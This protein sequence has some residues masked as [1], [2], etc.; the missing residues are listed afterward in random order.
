MQASI[1]SS[2]KIDFNLWTNYFFIAFAFSI[3][4]SKALIS[5]FSALIIISWFLEKGY[6]QKL[7]YIKQDS[8]SVSFLFLIV[9]S[10]FSLLWSPD[11]LYAIKFISVKYW[12][13]LIIPIMLTS[14]Q[15]KYIKYVF[16]AFLLSMLISEI[17]SYGIFFELWHYNNVSPTD[18]SPFMNHTDYSTFLSFALIIILSKLLTVKELLWKFLYSLY[19]ITGLA[20]LF[21]NGGR[22]GQVTFIITLSLITILYFKLSLKKIIG[23]F[24]A[25][26]LFLSLAYTISPNFHERANQ[27]KTDITSMYENNDYTGSLSTRI[28]LWIVGIETFMDHPIIGTGIGGET[29]EIESYGSKHGFSHLGTFTDYHN[30]FIQYGVQLGII[31]FLIPI[32]IFYKLFTLE[33]QTRQYKLLSTAFTTIYLLHAMGGFS[34]HILDSM[35]FLCTFAALFNA[36]SKQESAQITLVK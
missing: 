28:A 9:F 16:N 27:L 24:I 6:S 4:I 36:I 21:I 18:P 30:S 22:T 19:F 33:F 34:F 5:L 8:L 29:K 3:P 2:K 12:H 31:G 13:Y 20:N 32:F 23:L 11:I 17:V 15:L 14:F 26:L 7:E 10:L 35:V 25:L 1:T